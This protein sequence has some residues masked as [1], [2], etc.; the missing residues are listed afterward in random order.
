MQNNDYKKSLVLYIALLHLQLIWNFCRKSLPFPDNKG[1][2]SSLSMTIAETSDWTM[3]ASKMTVSLG[4][5]KV[6][7]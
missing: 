1:L 4:N 6:L 3:D 7:K 5:Y 2:G